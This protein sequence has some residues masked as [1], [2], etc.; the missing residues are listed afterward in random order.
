M[1]LIKKSLGVFLV[2]IWITLFFYVFNM[3]MPKGLLYVLIAF[4]TVLFSSIFILRKFDIK[5]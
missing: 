5:I 4:P 1:D 3:I 2:F